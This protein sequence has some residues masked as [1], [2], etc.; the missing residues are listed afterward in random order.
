MEDYKTKY[1]EW[2]NNP[3]FDEET[4]KPYED[5]YRVEK[6]CPGVALKQVGAHHIFAVPE[7]VEHNKGSNETP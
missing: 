3:S 1:E 7:D 2:L 4:R 6:G 5:D